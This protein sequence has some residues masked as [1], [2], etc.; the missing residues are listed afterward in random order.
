MPQRR[1][2]GLP[3][4]DAEGRD[5]IGFI[6]MNVP[7][8]RSPSTLSR[9]RSGTIGRGR[10]ASGGRWEQPVREAA[11]FEGRGGRQDTYAQR[12]RLLPEIERQHSWEEAEIEAERQLT[13]LS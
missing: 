11:R 6:D 10:G 4:S 8:G 5:C 1:G 12:P 9:H 2:S 7:H 3:V 13:L